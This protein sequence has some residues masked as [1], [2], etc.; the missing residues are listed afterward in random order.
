MLTLW[1]QM[2][3][4][5]SIEWLRFGNIAFH[6]LN[7]VLFA[8]ILERSQLSRLVIFLG[9]LA[10]AVH[11]LAT[12]PV[13]L[14]TG[15][16]DTV[17]ATLM[18]SALLVGPLHPRGWSAQRVVV[19]SLLVM[20]A[21]MSKESA[22]VFPVL[23]VVATILSERVRPDARLKWPLRA[24]A[25]AGPFLALVPVVVIR[26]ALGIK[27]SDPQMSTSVV[28]HLQTYGTILG[29]YARY[30][31]TFSQG[32]TSRPF[33]LDGF[34]SAIATLLVFAVGTV[35]VGV[36]ARR[37]LRSD[38]RWSGSARVGFG[39]FWFC[40]LLAPFVLAMPMS[41]RWGNR[42]GYLPSLGLLLVVASGVELMFDHLKERRRVV[43]AAGVVL[44]L[45]LC[46]LNTSIEAKNW[47][48]DVSLF[49]T[50]A[51]AEPD[52]WYALFFLG[53][54]MLP[55]QGCEGA[56]PYFARSARL[57]PTWLPVVRNARLCA[58]DLHRYTEAEE[59]S[60]IEVGLIP[61]DADA[62]ATLGEIRL[63]LGKLGE[64]SAAVSEGLRLHPRSRT[65]RL[66]SAQILG[67]QRKNAAAPES[68]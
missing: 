38:P 39:L 24:A 29:G 33:G 11:P 58:M 46:G 37:A 65:L 60:V 43:V 26:R 8:L 9:A 17:P 25:I 23:L 13:M 27:S 42:Y 21:A 61:A 45:T 53:A 34:G 36:A 66:L 18:L 20:F 59:F 41:G 35:G 64:A 19:S 40:V 31:L 68:P 7:V 48:D 54:A 44:L 3:V 67:A 50:D 62:H 6:S 12:E 14:I 30:T 22:F 5:S 47:H 49:L 57:N 10:M 2:R 16:H 32:S 1:A 51:E 4:S 52:N 28:E 63:R 15:R 56:G 55:G